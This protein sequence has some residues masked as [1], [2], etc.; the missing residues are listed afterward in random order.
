VRDSARVETE[1]TNGNIV[2]GVVSDITGR[3]RLEEQFFQSQKME[4]I[5]R[6]A[7]GV[8]H[9][10]N[11]I[12]T[13]IT[14]YTD[15]LLDRHPDHDDP[16]REEIE[17]IKKA[18]KQAASL[19]RQ[20]LAFSRKQVL[21][22]RVL[23]LNT[24]VANIETMLRRLIG[25]NIELVTILE[26]QLGRVKADPGQMEQVIVNLVVNARDAMPN[27]GKLIIKTTN[28]ELDETFARQHLGAGP[29]PYVLL[30]LNDTGHGMDP[31]TRSHI[32]EP[33]FT[34][35]EPGQGTG[36]GLAIVHGIINQSGGYI[37]VQSEPGQG[38]SFNIYLPRVETP[39]LATNERSE[40][41]IPS[42]SGSETILLVEDEDSVRE[43]TRRILLKEGYTV[44]EAQNG[45]EALQVLQ[46]YA[47][48]VDLLLTDVIMPGSV[49]GRELGKSVSLSHPKTKV[50][51][52]SGY[53]DNV[54]IPNGALD[55]ILAFLAKPFTPH[56]L[57]RKVRE[58]L[59]ARPA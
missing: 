34:T 45:E 3:K 13:V 31:Q 58:I 57:T 39:V 48:P 55:P 17:Q 14:G 50:L 30:T 7:G 41:P 54:I 6:L 33:F 2:Y 24:V 40:V 51:Y 11:N 16:E 47:Q 5:G 27:G 19:T 38:A 23:N 37:S 10:F 42:W 52:M 21:Q 59:D 8:A 9:D 43:L 12:L 56:A 46:E 28:L 22:P 26:P 15:L 53:T 44:L 32:F 20:L 49:N 29:G 25:E 35:K 1:G 36:L 18:T 4:A